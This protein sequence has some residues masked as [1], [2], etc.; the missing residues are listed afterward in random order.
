[1]GD[2]AAPLGKLAD[3]FHQVGAALGEFA[4]VLVAGGQ[5]Q[6]NAAVHGVV[7]QADA[8]GQAGL[9]V[10]VDQGGDARGATVA[11]GHAHR[12]PLLGHQHVPD[13]G[14]GGQRRHDGALAG[15]GV[16]E[17]VPHPLDPQ[18]LHEGLFSGH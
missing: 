18:H 6:G 7:Q 14:V 1:M 15:A 9:D 16:A 4:D 3:H 2:F 17:D 11:V 10:Q 8:V 13:V 12:H 5:H